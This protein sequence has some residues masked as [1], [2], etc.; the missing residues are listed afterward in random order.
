LLDSIVAKARAAHPDEL[1]GYVFFDDDNPQVTVS[2]AK[3]LDAP[4]EEFHLQVFDLRNG[5]PIETPPHNE[6]FM[7]IMLKL[8]TDMFAGLPGM[9][10]LGFMGILLA[11]AIISGVVLY[12]PFMRKLDFGTVRLARGN[13]VR[14]L[15]LHN[16]LGVV[17]VTW[18][19]VV[20]FTG[21]INTLGVIIERLWQ[22]SELADMASSHKDKPVPTPAQFASIDATLAAARTA[23]PGKRPV[24]LAFPG[25]PFSS[26]HHYGIYLTGDTPLTSRLLTPVLADGATGEVTAVREMPIYVQ[27]LFVSQ[28]LHFGDY[29]GLPLKIIWALF[30][31]VTIVVLGSGIYLWLKPKTRKEEVQ[32]VVRENADVM[33]PVAP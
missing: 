16:V 15:D 24:T 29:G 23:V 21:S 30:D 19:I 13:R 7:Y 27:A 3:K 26:P 25:S 2:L 22:A 8:H 33:Y 12:A 11:V 28:P 5:E 9:L 32:V 14:W 10:F 31:I 18:L 6:G 17:T 20:G 1:V 4:F